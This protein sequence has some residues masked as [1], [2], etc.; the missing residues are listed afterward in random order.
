MLVVLLVCGRRARNYA[1]C[2]ALLLLLLACV[3]GSGQ[4]RAKDGGHN[5]VINVRVVIALSGRRLCWHVRCRCACRGCSKAWAGLGGALPL[6]LLPLLLAGACCTPKAGLLLLLSS[7]LRA[8]T[9]AAAANVLLLLL[10]CGLPLWPA[11]AAR[12]VT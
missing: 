12:L 4:L 2:V 3:L 8:A 9:A 1:L 11:D 6:L 5:V 10:L 7:R